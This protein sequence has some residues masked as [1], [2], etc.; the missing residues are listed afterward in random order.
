M[1]TQFT[2]PVMVVSGRAILMTA[3]ITGRIFDT[4]LFV[5]ITGVA[6]PGL[7]LPCTRLLPGAAAKIPGLNPKHLNQRQR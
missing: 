5:A 7:A 6:V 4:S 3:G 1:V 2:V